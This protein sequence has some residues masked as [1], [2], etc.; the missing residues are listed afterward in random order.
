MYTLSLSASSGKHLAQ[1]FINP[2]QLT[3]LLDLMFLEEMVYQAGYLSGCI[4]N[5]SR[6]AFFQR[7][8]EKKCS[9][10]LVNSLS[11]GLVRVQLGK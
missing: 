1:D 6:K 3:S 4:Y 10:K 2:F 8:V 9:Q 7:L 11:R 5:W